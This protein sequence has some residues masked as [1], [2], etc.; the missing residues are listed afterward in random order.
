M[1][2]RQII[3]YSVNGKTY[4]ERFFYPL[5]DEEDE[6]SQLESGVLNVYPDVTFQEIDGFGCAITESVAYLLQIM[7][8]E[9]SSALISECFGP[10]GNKYKLL[11]MHLDSCDYSLEEYQAVEDPI[12]DPELSTFTI[13][14]DRKRA[15][16]FIKKAMEVSGEPLSILVSPW[17]PPAAWKTPPLKPKNEMSVYG[18][19]LMPKVDYN[20]PSRCNGGSLK[21]EFYPDWA[22]Y[23]VKYVEAYREEGL[24]VSMLSIQNESIAATSWD[25]C[26]W[27]AQEQKDFL[28]DHL[29]PAFKEAGLDDKVGI[30]IWDHNKERVLE[31]SQLVLDEETL[32]MV[33]GIAFHWYSGDH[34]EAVSM[35]GQAFPGKT[36]MASE[37]C[38][39]HAPGQSAMWMSMTGD[40]TLPETV[41]YR[42]AV[43]YAH[44][45]IGNLNA[46]MNRW[47]D[48][49]LCVDEQGGPRH[50]PGGFTAPVTAQ[51]DG[52]YR[53]TITFD[54]IGHFSKHILPGAYRVGIS[55]CDSKVEV[56]AAKNPDGTVAV[57]V[58]NSGYE[59][60]G[61]AIRVQGRV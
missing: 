53:K 13:E 25:S 39:L 4:Q 55:K 58:L 36:L 1:K 6:P 44:D 37:C 3:T 21:P 27:T 31:F 54:Y 49:N 42:D 48:W 12:E 2:A 46:G 56:T 7:S 19:F 43:A 51:T 35:A 26:V 20:T 33:E 17:S 40:K 16:P 34:F 50:T 60:Q 52:T 14:R 5:N 28:K 22:K 47:I 8:P 10:A 59:D 30:Y 32:P 61:Y 45:I 41:E 38:C 29:Y 15:I 11:R 23:L 18:G 9:T 57:V 24:P